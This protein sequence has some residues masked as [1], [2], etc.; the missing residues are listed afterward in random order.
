MK[1][2]EY[3]RLKITDIPE[4]TIEEYKLRDIVTPDGW[5]YLEI[6]RGMYGL[7]QSVIIA[8]EQLEKRLNK[9]G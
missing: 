8:Q 2:K 6:C 1:R 5:V 7:P 9:Q 3:T 4:E